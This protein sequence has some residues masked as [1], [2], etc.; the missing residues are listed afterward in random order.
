MDFWTSS[1]SGILKKK[2][3]LENECFCPPTSSPECVTDPVP[4]MF[5][6]Q[7]TK[8]RT[9]SRNSIIM[10][11]IFHHHDLFALGINYII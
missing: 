11:V 8:K 7:N 10:T 1:T 9:K 4:K 2:H 3:V 6:S 5:S